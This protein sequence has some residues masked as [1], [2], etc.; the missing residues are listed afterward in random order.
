M[1]Q[2]QLTPER[3]SDSRRMTAAAL[4]SVLVLQSAVGMAYREAVQFRNGLQRD[5]LTTQRR[6]IEK[7]ITMIP[8]GSVLGYTTNPEDHRFLAGTV[9][10]AS[11][12]GGIS[13][14][15]TPQQIYAID[16][17]FRTQYYAAPFRLKLFEGETDADHVVANFRPPY[18]RNP[19]YQMPRLRLVR[20][21][22]DGI[23]LYRRRTS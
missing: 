20:D 1:E 8:D 22:G 6:V 4:A 11:W 12:D 23:A 18:A 17:Y 5:P 2:S 15:F 14:D 3:T 10:S 9:L 21:F 7:L 16:R 19:P 13:A